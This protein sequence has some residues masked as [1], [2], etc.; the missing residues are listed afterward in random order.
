M[1]DDVE[2]LLPWYVNGTLAADERAAVERE[3]AH[4]ADLRA[5][6]AFWQLAAQAPRAG[7]AP[8]CARGAQGSRPSP[9]PSGL[10]E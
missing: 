9:P 5:A 2:S 6:L 7:A 4:N 10:V 1:R 8:A 3:L